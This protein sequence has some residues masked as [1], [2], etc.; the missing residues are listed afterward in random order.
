MSDG[1]TLEIGPG[2]VYEIP[3]DHDAWVVGDQPW[4]TVEWIRAPEWL[5]SFRTTHES[6]SWATVV[7]HRHRRLD[8]HPRAPRRRRLARSVAGPQRPTARGPGSI[9]RARGDDDRRRVPGG[10]RQPFPSG[11]CGRRDVP[12]RGRAWP[13]DPGRCPHRRDRA[14]RWATCPV[15]SRWHA[16]APCDDSLV[17]AGEVLGLVGPLRTG[18]RA[19]VRILRGRRRARAQGPV[20]RCSGLSGRR[21]LLVARTLTPSFIKLVSG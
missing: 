7:L 18:S 5:A 19:Q 9:P 1:Q 13:A 16:A 14:H 8:G 2:S 12:G 4:E 11:P 20:R 6:E 10:V 21:D 17:G 15:V 3:P